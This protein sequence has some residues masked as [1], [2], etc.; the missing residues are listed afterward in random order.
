MKK[1]AALLLALS[2]VLSLGSFALA[3]NDTDTTQ[4]STVTG[5]EATKFFPAN[6]QGTNSNDYVVVIAN[7]Y[8]SLVRMNAQGEIVPGPGHRMERVGGWPVLHVYASRRRKVPRRF[9]DDCG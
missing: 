6:E 9:F 8:D 2:L 5:A 4:R 3:E 7:L 1:L